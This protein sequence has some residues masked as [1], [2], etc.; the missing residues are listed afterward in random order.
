MSRIEAE[1]VD[2]KQNV[3]AFV[4]D[5]S[6]ALRDPLTICVGYLERLGDNPDEQRTTV[7]IVVKELDRMARIVNDLE[8]LI[9]ADEPDFLQPETID[10]ATFTHEL[11][12]AAS[13]LGP[14]RWVIDGTGVGSMMADHKRLTD[15]VMDL[16]DNAVQHTTPGATVAIGSSLSDDEARIWVRDTGTGISASDQAR[17]FR[18]F[19]RG[20]DAHRRYRGGGLGL[21]VVKAIVEAHGGWVELESRPGEGSTFTIVLR[22]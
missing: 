9:A 10:V 14:R 19:A 5:A 20:K 4:A 6:R 3:R 21:A 1:G 11:V 13:S 18:L 2:H 17:V 12:E 15:A 16:A 8:V 22:P 7:D